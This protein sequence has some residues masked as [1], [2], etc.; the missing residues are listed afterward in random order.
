MKLRFMKKKSGNYL[1]RPQSVHKLKHKI[2]ILGLDK[3]YY[4][5]KFEEN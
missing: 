1:K 3:S 5:G 2:S 4:L